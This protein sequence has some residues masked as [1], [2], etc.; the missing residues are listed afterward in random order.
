[1]LLNVTLPTMTCDLKF[2]LQKDFMTLPLNKNLINLM[3]K[4]C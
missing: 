2:K 1:M 3:R 4:S